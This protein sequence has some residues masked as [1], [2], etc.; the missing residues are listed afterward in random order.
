MNSRFASPDDHDAGLPLFRGRRGVAVFALMAVV[1]VGASY[2]IGVS[3]RE[4]AAHDAAS[5]FDA[6]TRAFCAGVGIAATSDAYGHCADGASDLRR[7]HER[8]LLS[9]LANL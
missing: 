6:E 4:V 2:A 8:R 1:V 3:E 7:R 5:A 9:D